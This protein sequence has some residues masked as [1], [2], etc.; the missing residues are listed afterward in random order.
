MIDGEVTDKELIG[1]EVTGGDVRGDEYFF[2][3]LLFFIEGDSADR[4]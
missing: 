1:G 4:D 3:G 2:G